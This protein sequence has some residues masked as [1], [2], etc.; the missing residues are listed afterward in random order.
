[1]LVVQHDTLHDFLFDGFRPGVVLVFLFR[2]I[3]QLVKGHMGGFFQCY[4][5][6]LFTVSLHKRWDDSS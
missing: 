5:L 1:M 2:L 6:L 4:L 3:D